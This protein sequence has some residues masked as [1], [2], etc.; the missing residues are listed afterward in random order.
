MNLQIKLPNINN[1]VANYTAFKRVGDLLFVAGQTCRENGQM[2]F[3]G[4]VGKDLSLEQAK[5]ASKLCALNILSQ[6]KI[7]CDE[8]LSKIKSCVRLNVFINCHHDFLDHA[9]VADGASDLMV[10]VFGENGKPTRTSVGIS[11]LPS[12]SAIE[13]DAIFEFYK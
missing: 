4:K 1:P 8:D 5:E 3:C 13:I 12:N 2:K 10:E 9:V 6:V 7:A 11:S